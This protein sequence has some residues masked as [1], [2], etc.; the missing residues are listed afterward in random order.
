M[1]AE[2]LL[3]RRIVYPEEEDGA[4]RDAES[5]DVPRDAESG[6]VSVGDCAPTDEDDLFGV[7][8]TPF[9][10]RATVDK[11]VGIGSTGITSF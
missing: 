1:V 10:V 8:H 7:G 3:P 6:A 11:L 5:G 9:S 2:R 4:P